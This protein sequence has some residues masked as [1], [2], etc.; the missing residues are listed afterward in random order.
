M[1]KHSSRKFM[2]RAQFNHH[3]YHHPD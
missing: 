1:N 3:H 2:T